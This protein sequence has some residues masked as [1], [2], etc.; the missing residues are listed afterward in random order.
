[1]Q[2][3]MDPTQRTMYYIAAAP[4]CEYARSI[5][6]A[7][8]MRPVATITVAICRCCCCCRQALLVKALIIILLCIIHINCKN[9]KDIY[10][11]SK[12]VHLFIFWTTLCQKLADFN[13]FCYV[14]SWENLTWN[15][16]YLSTS[17]VRCSHFT[18]GNPKNIQTLLFTYFR[19][20]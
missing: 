7:V 9:I 3:R 16:T 10:T 4:T 2:T 20:R 12:N 11:V 18:S 17:P 1:M 15:L 14:K 13:N 5:S 6:A 8:S 19:L